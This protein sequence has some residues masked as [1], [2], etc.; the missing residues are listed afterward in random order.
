MPSGSQGVNASPKHLPDIKGYICVTVRK[1]ANLLIFENQTFDL[2]T[3][4]YSEL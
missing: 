2:Y 4:I 3:G 1:F